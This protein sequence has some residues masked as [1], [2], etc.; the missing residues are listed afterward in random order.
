MNEFCGTSSKTL[1]NM[2]LDFRKYEGLPSEFKIATKLVLALPKANLN[3]LKKT[4]TYS[5]CVGFFR[6]ELLLKEE[7]SERI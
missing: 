1:I 7:K 6:D 3:F 5:I 2:E 4:F